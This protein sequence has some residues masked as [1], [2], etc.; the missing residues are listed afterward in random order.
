MVEHTRACSFK[1]ACRLYGRQ[2]AQ[3]AAGLSMVSVE[4]NVRG[5]RGAWRENL[6]S[7]LDA[8]TSFG[9]HRRVLCDSGGPCHG[10]HGHFQL[11]DVVLLF[12]ILLLELTHLLH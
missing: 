8:L 6:P 11:V 5:G 2:H 12:T 9:I 7:S 1:Y 3:F 10:G 4:D